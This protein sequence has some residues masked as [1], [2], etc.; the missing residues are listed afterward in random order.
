MVNKKIILSVLV[1]GCIVTVAGAGTWA[2]FDDTEIS[3]NNTITTGT[4]ELTPG[5]GTLDSFTVDHIVPGDSQLIKTVTLKN[6]GD[7]KGYLY[8]EISTSNE[9]AVKD[10]ETTIDGQKMYNTAKI[11]LGDLPA[12]GQS[13]TY[14]IRYNFVETH[15]N[16][17][18][19]KNK[20]V[21]YTITYR[22]QQL[23]NNNGNNND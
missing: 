16:Q 21:T 23:K 8:A 4:I 19:Q 22:L 18:T 2:Y 13:K 20:A 14:E 12:N 17:N 15:N 1:I 11:Y 3:G 9:G 10:L 6:T 5:E 7:V